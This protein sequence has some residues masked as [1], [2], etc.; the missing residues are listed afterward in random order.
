VHAPVILSKSARGGVP[1]P[2]NTFY[3]DDLYGITDNNGNVV[4]RVVDYLK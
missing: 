3:K 2:G 4:C 1:D